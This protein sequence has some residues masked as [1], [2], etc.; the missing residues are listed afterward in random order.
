MNY[1]EY[2]TYCR[3]IAKVSDNKNLPDL[4]INNPLIV[5]SIE[6]YQ[7]KISRI[8][9]SIFE[10][11]HGWNNSD[12]LFINYDNINKLPEVISLGN[13]FCKIL[14]KEFFGC[15]VVFDRIEC[16][17]NKVTNSS[18]H[19]SWKWHYD[20]CA[21]YRYK[22]MVYLSDVNVDNGGMKVLLNKDKSCIS[23]KSSRIKM[24]QK[25]SP[26]YEGSRIPDSVI[27]Q[28]MKNGFTAEEI[29]GPMGTTLFFH[30]NIA[31]KAT[32]PTKEP[33]R[34]CLIY[35]FRPYHKILSDSFFINRSDGSNNGGVKDYSTSLE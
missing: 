23:Y 16:Y 34:T 2:Y 4:E 35:N 8:S 19:S 33:S 12:S 18:E 14:S 5:N 24:G 31:H 20:D 10:D 17:K 28:H 27:D 13:E 7:E 22:I 29:M 30:Q 32:I 15:Q 9:T 21:P 26:L 11:T 1:E 6:N 25:K 3:N